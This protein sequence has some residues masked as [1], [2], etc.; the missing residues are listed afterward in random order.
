MTNGEK[1][2]EIFP[3]YNIE[4]VEYKGYVRVFYKYFYAIYPLKWWNT[5]YKESTT[6]NDC[7]E[8]NGC[9]SCSLDDGDDCC[10]KL[11]EESMREPT[12][13]NDLGVDCISRAELLKA[14]DTWDKFGYTAQ[15]GLERLDKDDKGFVPYVKY[16]DM[17]NCVKGM[18]SVTPQEPILDK[19]RAE[20]EKAVWED[21]IVSLDGMDE[22]RIPRLEP[23]DV[24]KI[25]DKYRAESEK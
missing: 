14:M 25:I 13:K 4:I 9:I 16:D 6:K 19:I 12:T 5:K 1:L 23:S 22:V 11:Y 21:V 18:P 15:Y 8:Q 10:R 7:A 3:D 20:I 2:I 17:V 24:F